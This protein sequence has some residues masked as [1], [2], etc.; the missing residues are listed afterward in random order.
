MDWFLRAAE[1]DATIELLPDTLVYHRMHSNNLS[2]RQGPEG[3]QEF[4]QIVKRSL[5][6]RRKSGREALPFEHFLGPGV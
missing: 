1:H 4:L 3:R 6:S 5:E 2:R